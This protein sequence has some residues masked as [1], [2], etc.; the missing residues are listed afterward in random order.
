MS[1]LSYK[2]ISPITIMKERT[3]FDES[4]FTTAKTFITRGAAVLLLDVI[5]TKQR[6]PITFDFAGD[7]FIIL[8]FQ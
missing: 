4:M 2:I 6:K 1:V 3:C 7:H 5:D 8:L